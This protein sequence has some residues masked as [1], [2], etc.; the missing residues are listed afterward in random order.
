MPCYFPLT[1]F[2][3]PP[4]GTAAKR[5]LF[6]RDAP[7]LVECLIPCGNCIGCRLDKSRTWAARLM[8]ELRMHNNV[9]YFVTLTLSDDNLEFS[10]LTGAATLVK[11]HLQKFFKRLRKAGYAIRY[12]AVG[13]YGEQ[14]GR[15][16]YHAIIF[17]LDFSDRRLYGKSNGLNLYTSATLDRIWSLGQ[18]FIGDI[19]FESCAYCARYVLKKLTGNMAGLYAYE[20]ILPEFALMSRRPGIGSSF[21]DRFST[22]IFP[23]DICVIRGNVVISPPRYYSNKFSLSDPV[24]FSVIKSLRESRSALS[25]DNSTSD[26]LAVR[27]AV[28]MAQLTNL[29]RQF[30]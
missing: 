12:Y 2:R 7:G 30:Q 1:A 4:D 14:T 6:F 10:E 25:I 19:T 11:S 17:G 22:D 20:D 27:H 9:G 13:E 29:L 24:S 3:S 18:C 23:A 16:H 8:H 5:P 28:K 21:Y 15:P 26:R